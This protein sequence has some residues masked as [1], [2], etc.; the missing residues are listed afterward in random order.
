MNP[1]VVEDKWA[2][3]S[4]A[5]QRLNGNAPLYLEFGVFEGRSMRWW[6]EHLTMPGAALVGFDSFEGLPENW[7]PGFDSRLSRVS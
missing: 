7:R 3:F 2:L 1:V 5:L 6:S 4:M